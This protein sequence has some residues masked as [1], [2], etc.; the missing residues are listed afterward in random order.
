MKCYKN[1][2][3][4]ERKKKTGR[5]FQSLTHSFCMPKVSNTHA[6]VA[7]SFKPRINFCFSHHK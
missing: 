2:R 3:K 4:E 1:I 6:A 7:Q 5:S